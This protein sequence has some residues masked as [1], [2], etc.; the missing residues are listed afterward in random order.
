MST[1]SAQCCVLQFNYLIEWTWFVDISAGRFQSCQEFASCK[2]Q[3]PLE[4]SLPD[5]GW[6]VD[7]LL[8][9]EN[10]SK[11]ARSWF[12]LKRWDI[13]LNFKGRKEDNV[14]VII[15]GSK[16]LFL[17]WRAGGE[18]YF[19]CTNKYI[20]EKSARSGLLCDC[21]RYTNCITYTLHFLFEIL[22]DLMFTLLN[23]GK[24]VGPWCSCSD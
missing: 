14:L 22:G 19:F 13:T 4:R 12:Y 16:F 3:L 17:L 11:I 10:S 7:E 2:H 15:R 9:G 6:R 20:L 5:A 1:P 21:H 18:V 24:G 23:N 8:R